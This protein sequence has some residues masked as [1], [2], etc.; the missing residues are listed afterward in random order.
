[1]IRSIHVFVDVRMD[2]R[3]ALIV[4]L[5]I[6]STDAL[7]STTRLKGLIDSLISGWKWWFDAFMRK[8]S[9][10]HWNLC[11]DVNRCDVR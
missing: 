9:A 5:A 2:G 11:L 7:V 8:P 10:P 3:P 4:R 1:M 6:R